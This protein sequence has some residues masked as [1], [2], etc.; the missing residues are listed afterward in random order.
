MQVPWRIDVD[1]MQVP[2]CVLKVLPLSTFVGFI[3]YSD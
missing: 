3:M 1:F 2:V